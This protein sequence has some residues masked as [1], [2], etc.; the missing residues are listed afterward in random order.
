MITLNFIPSKHS[1]SVGV[2][3]EYTTSHVHSIKTLEQFSK[4]ACQTAKS[5]QMHATRMHEAVSS[6][7]LKLSTAARRPL[8]HPA[9]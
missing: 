8:V 7:C 2:H 4:T 3:Q 9:L 6:S 1:V 5:K